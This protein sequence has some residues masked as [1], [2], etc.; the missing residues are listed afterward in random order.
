MQTV[1]LQQHLF[2]VRQRGGGKIS[3]SSWPSIFSTICSPLSGAI[4]PLSISRPSRSTV[5]VSQI[6]FSSWIRCEI[7]TTPIP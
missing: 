1:N 6:A 4:G 7:N 3:L 2:A 5:R